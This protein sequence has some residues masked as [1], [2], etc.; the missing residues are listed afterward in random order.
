MPK[1]PARE[2]VAA[3]E[4]APAPRRS[5][6]RW[7][8]GL[9]VLGA[10]AW[11][12]V[13]FVNH[14]LHYETT[15]DA[16]IRTHVHQ[17]SARVSGTISEVLVKDHEAVKAGQVLARLESTEFA[18]ALERAKAALLQS[19]AEEREAD[20]AISHAKAQ[21]LQAVA[22]V[23]QAEAQVTQ[24]G[25]EQETASINYARNQNLFQS[26]ARAVAKADVD[27][28]RGNA[29]SMRAAVEGARASVDAARAQSQAAEVAVTA[30][31][32]KLEAAKAN[33]Q[34]RQAAVRDAERELS[35][36]EIK[37]PVD[38]HIGNKSVEPGDRVQVGQ[39]LFAD[40]EPHGWIVANFKETQLK[41]MNV[42]QAVDVTVDAIEGRTF[43][44]HIESISPATGA[45]FAL[46][47]PDNAGGNF[48]KVVQRVPVKVTFD[49][50]SIRGVEDRLQAGLSVVVNVRVK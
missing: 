11:W 3:P 37:A 40:V 22:Q 14:L 30:A 5:P 32:A 9:L 23:K 47:P 33:V 17:V 44:G 49:A 1:P 34:V 29:E 15:D 28:A 16:F 18:I 35:Y 6:V 4:A 21:A 48:T 36:T 41:K 8:I 27:T 10:I 12:G 26:N 19:Q 45:Q 24:S 25:A 2:R 39:I 7:I 42:G 20:A 13:G 46:L 38:G 50:E 31:Q 43:A